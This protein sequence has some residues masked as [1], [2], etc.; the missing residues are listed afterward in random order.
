MSLLK[1]E[2]F[3]IEAFCWIYQIW[4]VETSVIQHFM[5]N[6]ANSWPPAWETCWLYVNNPTS[7]CIYDNIAWLASLLIHHIHFAAFIF[8]VWSLFDCLVKWLMFSLCS[9]YISKRFLPR[10]LLLWKFSDQKFCK[11]F[12][13]K[14]CLIWSERL[15]ECENELE[16][17]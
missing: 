10:V 3:N 13:Y 16:G 15:D 1:S 8:N 2:C 11:S 4:S 17:P 12:Q 7:T 6:L 14:T 9:N 5:D